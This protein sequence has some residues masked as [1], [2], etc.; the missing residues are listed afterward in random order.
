MPQRQ[1]GLKDDLDLRTLIVPIANDTQCLGARFERL[2]N[3][4]DGRMHGRMD[5]HMDDRIEN[6]MD[7]RLKSVPG[8][9]PG[10]GIA[11]FD[12]ALSRERN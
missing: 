8:D 4:M 1:N 2:Y 9:L 12:P 10:T 11:G 5:G 7:K 3:R 6:S